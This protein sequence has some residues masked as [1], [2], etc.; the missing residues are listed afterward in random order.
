MRVWVSIAE[1]VSSL[2]IIGFH[3]LQCLHDETC[4]TQDDIVLV[5]YIG[6]AFLLAC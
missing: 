3:L 5:C 6:C 1:P 2:F 4:E